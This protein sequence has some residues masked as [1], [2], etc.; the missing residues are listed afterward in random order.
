MEKLPPGTVSRVQV[1]ELRQRLE[2]AAAGIYDAVFDPPTPG[3]QS[4]ILEKLACIFAL[5]AHL[6]P[7]PN[8]HGLV[9]LSRHVYKRTS[10]FLHGRSH[11]LHVPTVVIQEWLQVVEAVEHV[12]AQ[13]P[14]PGAEPEE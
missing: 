7:Q 11:M 13:M 2:I 4:A 6:S 10:D 14:G 5:D 9:C 1:L 8:R 12:R 3:D